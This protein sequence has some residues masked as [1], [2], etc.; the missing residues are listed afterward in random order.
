MDDIWSLFKEHFSEIIGNNDYYSRRLKFLQQYEN[1]V[2]LYGA[3]GFP[4]DLY[5]N[6]IIKAKFDITSIYKTEYVWNK[7]VPYC[8]NPHFLEINLMHP[9]LTK[10]V[11]GLCPFLTHVI[12]TKN[13]SGS[14]HFIIIKNIDLLDNDNSI[15]YRIILERFSANAYFLCTAHNI[16]KIDAPIK[17]RFSLIRMPLFSN[18]EIKD[19]FDRY[20]KTPLN[21]H[22]AADKN[23][24]DVIKALYI[25]DQECTEDVVTLNF[26]PIVEF[27]EKKKKCTLQDVRQFAYKCFQYNISIPELVKDILKLSPNSKKIG[28]IKAGADIEHQLKLAHRGREAI[29][30]EAFLCKIMF[31]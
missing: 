3:Y 26:P 21:K 13:V 19:I 1:N 11:S 2:L 18:R 23:M 12:K 15:S 14:K 24:R 22:L 7:D 4:T 6:E 9:M 25:G 10:D 30:I 20:L 17:S 16:D 28:I 8:H 29:Y 31:M 27:L 5:I